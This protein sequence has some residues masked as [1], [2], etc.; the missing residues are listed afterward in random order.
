MDTKLVNTIK[1][2][3][4]YVKDKQFSDDK[5]QDV[6]SDCLMRYTNTW[7]RYDQSPIKLINCIKKFYKN[8]LNGRY[9]KLKSLIILPTINETN[10][11]LLMKSIYFEKIYESK[12]KISFE[13]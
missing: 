2:Y 7:E 6:L 11:L 13:N 4:E 12:P 9:L 10:N 3:N 1:F 5:L 8:K